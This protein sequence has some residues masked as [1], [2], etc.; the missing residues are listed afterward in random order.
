MAKSIY[1][2]IDS[3]SKNEVAVFIDD[4]CKY[5]S[6]T[7]Y[8]PNELYPEYPFRENNIE[9]TSVLEKDSYYAVRQIFHLLEYD[10][11]NFGTK[12][13]DPLGH[14]IKPGQNVVLKP[15]FILHYNEAGYD[16]YASLTH[17]S[18]IRAM[19]D[20]CYIAMK[21]KGN[22][23]IAEAP[24]MN[25]EFDK[26]EEL[27]KLQSIKEFY[28][29][30]A[31]FDFNIIDIRRLK[32]KFDY[33]KGYFPSDSFVTNE[34]ADPLG[35]TIIDLGNESYLHGI[36]GLENL[37]GADYDRKFTV[38]NH[39]RGVHK[40]CI[41]NT[42]LNADTVICLPKLK[43]HKK[44][45]VTLNIKLLVGINGDK[46][47]LAHYRIGTADQNGDEYPTT[48]KTNVRISR[49]VARF[50]NDNLFAKRSKF[51]DQ[52][53]LLIKTIGQPVLN[54]L[55]NKNIVLLPDEKDRVY[56]GNWYGNDTAWRMACDLARILFYS[57]KNGKIKS[58]P[59][60]NILSVVDGII[61]GEGDGPMS[62]EPKNI[63]TLI[64]GENILAVDTACATLMG[65]DYRKIK[66]LSNSWKKNKFSIVDFSPVKSKI[67][68]N[69]PSINESS[70]ENCM[71]FNFKPHPQ[72]EGHIELDE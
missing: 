37:Y 3:R 59:Q 30:E 19:A 27:M 2:I 29:K 43:T 21:G 14:I 56:G 33:D 10:I 69:I 47:Y 53:F 49:K 13:W 31:N 50:I 71:F 8:H 41:S 24:Q 38:A 70:V 12:N 61:A 16:I 11:N 32:C 46:N 40:Y 15:N 6:N 64:S 25:C 35:Y 66:M 45:G 68:S 60:R 63:G 4:K 39:S 18:V 5:S 9:K 22:L 55:R 20:Y 48:S 72:W 26:I 62:P 57:D 1:P 23:C 58:V 51:T 17:P 36:I 7:P 52:I 44:V 28:K 65:F 34:N 54:F 42:I 67:K